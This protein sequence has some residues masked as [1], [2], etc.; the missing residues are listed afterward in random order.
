MA[1]TST[2]SS[3]SGASR[4][5][6]TCPPNTSN[7]SRCPGIALVGRAGRERRPKGVPVG[8]TTVHYLYDANSQ[9]IAETSADGTVQREYIYLD[10][11]P[12]AARDDPSP[13][14]PGWHHDIAAGGTLSI[15]VPAGSHTI[16]VA[17]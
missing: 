11:E 16:T 1:R 3:P 9:L 7:S 13:A 17:W 15:A 6:A 5:K 8:E 10:G 2:Y 14:N 12:L 4:S